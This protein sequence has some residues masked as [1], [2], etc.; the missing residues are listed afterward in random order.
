MIDG[1]TILQ[2]VLSPYQVEEYLYRGKTNVTGDV[3]RAADL[4]PFANNLE[5]AFKNVRL[6]YYVENKSLPGAYDG[7]DYVKAIEKGEDLYVLRFTTYAS[8]TNNMYSKVNE[9]NK[10]PC[11][12]TGFTAS[13]EH[14]IPEFNCS[15]KYD[16][17]LNQLGI[18]ISG[19]AIFRIEPSG[20]EIMIGCWDD[21]EGHFMVL[22]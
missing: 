5:E 10:P 11:T 19:G 2:K 12:G 14:L 16:E 7:N 6:D 3:Y 4:A 13:S 18:E 22:N 17:T 20:K 8:F 1:K 9:Y 15:M 21:I